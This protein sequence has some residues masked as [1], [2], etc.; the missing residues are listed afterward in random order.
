M[1][2]I[3]FD[4]NA[5]AMKMMVDA[6]IE[7]QQTDFVKNV[8]RSLNP[9]AVLQ[10]VNTLK[11][12]VPR[13]FGKSTF[14]AD[15]AQPDDLIIVPHARDVRTMALAIY[16]AAT[17]KFRGLVG[18]GVGSVVMTVEIPLILS[19]LDSVRYFRGRTGKDFGTVWVDEP[20]HPMYTNGRDNHALEEMFH[21]AF[22][23]R[24]TLARLITIGT[25]YTAF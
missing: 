6:F 1:S 20:Q 15:N 4:K 11:L 14:I 13:Q 18:T 16:D 7:N 23:G 5:V 12:S 2:D 9:A 17:A 19:A 21:Q 25:D 24:N 10:E 3:N 8:G 22:I